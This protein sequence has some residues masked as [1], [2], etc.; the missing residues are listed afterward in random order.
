MPTITFDQSGFGLP[1]GVVDRSRSDLFL[2]HSV[3]VTA[4]GIV[5]N[6]VFAL[7]DRPDGSSA[8]LGPD[9]ATTRVITPDVEGKY[10]V[11]VV[12]DD[13]NSEVIHTFT[14][15]TFLRG[16]A[17]PAHN[18]RANEDANDD[19]NDAADIAASE[20]NEGGHFKGWHK[21]DEESMRLFEDADR[22]RLVWDHFVTANLD[23]DEHGVMGWR[24]LQ[25]GTG[26]DKDTAPEAGHPGVVDL[27]CGTAAA[28]RVSIYLGDQS[29]FENFILDG[30]QPDLQCEWLVK[31]SGSIGTSDLER[32]TLGW[33]D[34]WVSGASTQ[35]NN[36]V[37]VEFDPSVSGFFRLRT[38]EGGS[39]SEEAGTTAVVL[40]TWYRVGIKITWSG[41]VGT[42]RM[43]ING[44]TEGNDLNSTDDDWP[45]VGVGY[46]ARG[47]AGASVGTE[48]RLR[49]DYTVCTQDTLKED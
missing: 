19:D 48:A 5:G 45:T 6:A 3:T 9:T 24:I 2:G 13:D 43:Y 32:I 25:T 22:H 30:Q 10:C 47:E 44:I 39:R 12:D 15:R 31:I 11:S 1:T 38:A 28:G 21:D 16:V 23:T 36:G 35:H 34:E 14:V 8:S 33:G 7:L 4:G 46:G 26:S 20:T 37:Y 17:I 18:E 49:I 42:A 41:G 27:G 29:L 40:N